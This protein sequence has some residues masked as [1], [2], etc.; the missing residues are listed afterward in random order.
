M[1]RLSFRCLTQK[2]TQN[3]RRWTNAGTYELGSL[4]V[5]KGLADIPGPRDFPYIGSLLHYRRGP[6][7]KF[8]V[9]KYQDAVISRYK[10]Y[11][12]IVKETMLGVTSVRIFDP[13]DVRT[14]FQNEDKQPFVDP[15]LETNKLYRDQRNLSQGIGNTNGEEWYTLRGAVQQMMMRPQAVTVYLP[16]VEDIVDDFIKRIRKI[17]NKNNEIDYFNY[18][19]SK[20][21]LESSA[22]TCFERRLG[23]LDDEP[24]PQVRRL[25]ESNDAVF[26]LSAYLKFCIPFYKYVST[27]T[28][29]KLVREEDCFFGGGQ[30][31]VDETIADI[32]RL[33][34]E[35]KLA[36]DRYHFMMHLLSKRELTYKDISIIALSLFGD[37]LSSTAPTLVFTMYLL[38][39]NPEA[40]EKAYREVCD[41]LK[42]GGPIT[43]AHIGKLVYLKA[44]VKESHRL[45]PINIEVKRILKKDL[46]LQGFSLPAGTV[47][48]MQPFVH[49]KSRDYFVDPETFLPERWLRD[50]TSRNIHP[51]LLTPF[52]HG[53]R[54]CIGRRF[55][56]QELFV[57]L[58]KML[59]NFKLEYNH[60]ELDMRYQVLMVPDRN[61][62]FTFRD[63]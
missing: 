62:T 32:D 46:N 20:W 38:A 56:E 43:P 50:G 53:P 26:K 16:F 41:V 34:M 21:N 60:G 51:F 35:G 58:S 11:G 14:I 44:C 54:M 12:S 42:D 13:D 55:A 18:E 9:E 25:I 47:I 24:G 40:Q 19:A 4:D 5:Q 57:V 49:Y 3:F 7:Q 17:R 28:W 63:R 59:K 29:K 23:S 10:K 61:T 30:V 52:G 31:L 15:L 33:R 2:S 39:K 48:E 6:M 36:G 22:M 37:G 27:T 45:F 1:R 8:T